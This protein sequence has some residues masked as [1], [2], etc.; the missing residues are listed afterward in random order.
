MRSLRLRGVYG[1]G[2]FTVMGSLQLWGVYSY[3]ELTS[4]GVTQEHY[5][6]KGKRAR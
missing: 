1:Y 5:K 2:E 4:M 6:E 3:G